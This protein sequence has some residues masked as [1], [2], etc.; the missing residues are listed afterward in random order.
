MC[1]WLPLRYPRPAAMLPPPPTRSLTPALLSHLL[2]HLLCDRF[3]LLW[4]GLIAQILGRLVFFLVIFYWVAFC[5]VDFCW[6]V[7]NGSLL[8]LVGSLRRLGSRRFLWFGEARGVEGV[9]DFVL[10]VLE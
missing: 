7:V 2:G 3:R 10:P 5:L 8:W 9:D 1:R 4:L 6:V